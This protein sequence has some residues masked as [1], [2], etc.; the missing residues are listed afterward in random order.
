MRRVF[1]A[2]QLDGTVASAKVSAFAA[3]LHIAAS[4]ANARCDGGCSDG[5]LRTRAFAKHRADGTGKHTQ[6]RHHIVAHRRF[7]DAQ[8]GA[9]AQKKC[10]AADHEHH[11]AVRPGHHRIARFDDRLVIDAL[12]ID[13]HHTLDF[14][15]GVGLPLRPEGWRGTASSQTGGTLQEAAPR[16]K[17]RCNAGGE[18]GFKTIHARAPMNVVRDDT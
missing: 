8:L 6:T 16:Y 17:C 2:G 14:V 10:I 4:A 15:N 9:L 18:D 11:L 3:R 7:I 1:H 13:A 5:D 12:A